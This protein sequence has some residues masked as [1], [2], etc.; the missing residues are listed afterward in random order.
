MIIL[1]TLA[2]YMFFHARRHGHSHEWGGG[3]VD[4]T[5]TG[6]HAVPEEVNAVNVTLAH[7]E[8]YGRWAVQHT[9]VGVSLPR[10]RT[11]VKNGGGTAR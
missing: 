3:R 8:F 11:G 6:T 7:P 10:R 4:V 2:R 9:R 1:L 5:P